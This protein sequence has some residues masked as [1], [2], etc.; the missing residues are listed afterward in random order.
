[1]IPCRQ[2]LEGV[3]GMLDYQT[4]AGLLKGE[5]PPDYC[6]WNRFFGRAV[7]YVATQ[8]MLSPSYECTLLYYDVVLKLK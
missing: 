1:M 4:E 7:M 8:A 2:G 5:N 3:H 6:W